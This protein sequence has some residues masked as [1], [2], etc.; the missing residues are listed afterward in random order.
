[1]LPKKKNSSLILSHRKFKPDYD[2]IFLH[3]P[4]DSLSQFI[5]RIQTSFTN[6]L[7]RLVSP[8][9]KPFFS[10]TLFEALKEEH[11]KIVSII[12]RSAMLRIAQDRA[13]EYLQKIVKNAEAVPVTN[14]KNPSVKILKRANALCQRNEDYSKAIEFLNLKEKENLPVHIQQLLRAKV[15]SAV[16][17]PIFVGTQP[18]GVLWGVSNFTYA[19]SIK[20][21]LTDRL[22]SLLKAISD[23][24]RIELDIGK[25]DTLSIRKVIES[26][27]SFCRYESILFT[28][29]SNSLNPPRTIIGYS[30]QYNVKFRTDSNYVIPTNRGFAISLKRYTPE[31]VLDKSTVLLMIPGFFCN[32]ILM[33][34]LAKEM[35]YKY[36]YVVFTLDVRGRS[37]YTFT[38]SFT[39]TWT[40]DDYIM[41]DFPI[42]LQWLYDQYPAAKFV[43][44]GHSMGGMIPR[45]YTSVYDKLKLKENLVVLPDPNDRIKGVVTISSPSYINV[46]SSLPGFELLKKTVKLLGKNTVSQT[47]ISLVS[48]TISAGLPVISLN[49]FFQF[50]HGMGDSIKD[51]IF[52]VSTKNTTVKNFVGYPQIT[53]PEWHVFLEDIFC[54][55]SIYGI[56]QFLKGQISDNGF[57]SFD[58][59]INYTQELKKFT[60]PLFTISGSIDT[61]APP[62]TVLCVNNLVSSKIK[63]IRSFPQ[64]HL[65]V[66]VHPPTVKEIALDTHN[67][68]KDII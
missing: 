37:S 51:L 35:A 44:Y 52:N 31:K 63:E 14:A 60:I 7:A 50:L 23:I 58:D 62:E 47:I 30:Y 39:T 64:G 11:L 45:F 17:I 28:H 57:W 15:R 32:R 5:Q 8:E 13:P 48:Q 33:D 67:W 29:C 3:S 41:Y 40:I 22:S 6:L 1:M 42:A 20:A 10:Y 34:L 4:G 65:G 66:I 2:D 18:V 56:A 54:K 9:D 19:P 21:E 12:N 27:D 49:Q 38:S 68:I 36:G 24:L 61:I 46:Q 16:G 43:I 25:G 59:T 53:P 55:E 26:L